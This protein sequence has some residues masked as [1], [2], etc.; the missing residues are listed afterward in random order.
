MRNDDRRESFD[1]KYRRRTHALDEHD[2]VQFEKIDDDDLKDVDSHEHVEKKEEKLPHDDVNE[3]NEV[4]KEDTPKPRAKREKSSFLPGLL[5]G[6]IGAILVVSLYHF[7]SNDSN[8]TNDV[9]NNTKDTA[10][11][12]QE[13]ESKHEDKVITDTIVAVEK[14]K[15]A[16]VSVINLQSQTNLFG[17]ESSL[18][19]AGT[20]SGVIYKTDDEYAYVIT[21]NHVIDK[22]TEVQVN[23]SEGDSVEAEILGTDIWT[24]LA[25]LR[26]PKGNITD[27]IEFGDSDKLLVGEEAI[28]IGSPLGDMFS[29]SVSRGIVSALDRRVPV[30][31]DGN[32]TDDWEAAVL[33]TDAAINPGNSGGALVNSKGELIGI[34]SMKIGLENVEGIGFAIPSNDVKAIVSELETG[35]EV[36]RPFIG[37]G[38]LDLYLISTS[39]QRNY[40]KLPSNVKQGVVLSSIEPGS[41]AEYAGLEELA[42]VTKL[43]DTEVNNAMEFRQYLYGNKKSGD[44]ITVTYYLDGRQYE[45]DVQL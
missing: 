12:R 27:V 39:D 1:E 18:A 6:I 35:G 20:G 10:E 45:T 34:N 43:D 13:I 2:T 14:A 23:T 16:V 37:V 25:V 32:G 36:D 19:E 29:G 4:P 5:A 38:L 42:V 40:L 24:D 30:D 17:N 26:M 9:V 21:N 28:A 3:A 41:P 11:V 31:I 44:T 22:A 8:N 7:L 15:P 33:Q